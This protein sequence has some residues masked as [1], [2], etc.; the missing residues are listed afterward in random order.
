MKNKFLKSGVNFVKKNSSTILKTIGITGLMYG[1]YH[2]GKVSDKALDHAKADSVEKYGDEESYTK[3][4]YVKSTWKHYLPA[5]VSITA[6]AACVIGA[7]KIDHKKNAALAT[8]YALSVDTAK[9]FELY[10]DKVVET[11][12]EKKAAAIQQKA[13][14][15]LLK[16]HPVEKTEVYNTGKGNHRCYDKISGRYFISDVN[17]IQSAVNALNHEM[18]NTFYVS[19][20]DFYYQIGLKEVKIGDMLGWNANDGLIEVIFDAVVAEDGTPC[21]VI[22]Y[23]ISPKYD[24]KGLH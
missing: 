2:I 9:N 22:D 10:K 21:I 15:E 18:N 12:G 1:A 17:T 23:A 5:V 3:V 20:N 11:L 19:L 4:D 14:E 16:R 7:E 6:G 8:A 13:D 24:F